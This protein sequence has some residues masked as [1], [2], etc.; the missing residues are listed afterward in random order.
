MKIPSL[1][2]Q[3]IITS[4]KFCLIVPIALIVRK[5]RKNIWIISERYDQARDNGYC[6]FKYVREE[7]KE[8]EIY[9][10]IDKKAADYQKIKDF[11]NVI[12]YDSWKHFLY[13]CIANVHISAHVG[14]CAPSNSPICRRLKPILKY[15]TVFIPHGVSYGIAEFCLQKYA[16]I[17]LFV[18]SGKLEYENVLKNYG[19]SQ[20][21]VVYTGFPR[22]DSWHK[23][24]V[25]P[26]QILV[27]PTW[28][29]YL[30]QNPNTVFEN[31]TYYRHYQELLQD[32]M[33]H[34]FL[35]ENDLKLIFYLHHNMQKYVNSF[36]TDCPNIEI[37]YKEETYDIQ[38]LL[39]SSAIMIT[40][41]SSVHFDFAYMKKPVI[42]YQF[43]KEEFLNKQ[44]T[45][46]MFVFETMGFGPLVY[47]KKHLIREIQDSWKSGFSVQKIYNDRM[48]KFYQIY[49][50][51][52]CER[53]YD[54]V[55]KLVGTSMCEKKR[56]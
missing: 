30:A 44:Y 38:E 23:V 10:I 25:N 22:Q 17:D 50:D 21:E 49:D 53:V 13:Y 18:C 55:I 52:N 43:D 7:Q 11:E 32:K 47:E 27:M 19:Y 46:G 39:K 35:E 4:I 31:T 40:D 26:K 28:R 9:Y 54:E 37:V 42:Y 20:K 29:L 24:E 41:Y 2:K 12:Q 3:N 14:G 8:Q 48:H 33:L 16:K 45:S 15:K 5:F 1:N 56:K 6:F 34:K 36:S 51:N